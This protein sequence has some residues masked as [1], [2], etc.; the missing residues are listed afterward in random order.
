MAVKELSISSPLNLLYQC[1]ALLALSSPLPL[2]LWTPSFGGSLL[3]TA[4]GLL[5]LIM[6]SVDHT[7]QQRMFTSDL[8]SMSIELWTSISLTSCGQFGSL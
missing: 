8:A 3:I 7:C 1:L 2:L 6:T 4:I 5:G